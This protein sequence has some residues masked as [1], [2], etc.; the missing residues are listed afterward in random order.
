MTDHDPAS[1]IERLNALITPDLHEHVDGTNRAAVLGWGTTF[2]VL[3]LVKGVRLL[4]EAD[5]CYVAMPLM[6]SML[7][8]AMG[9]IWIAD[10]QEDAVEVLNRRLLGQHN[11]LLKDLGGVDLE[12]LVGAETVAAF[13]RT[14]AEK[15]DP[16]PDERLI[17]FANLLREYNL[18]GLVPIYDVLSG[19]AHLSTQAAGAFF[20]TTDEAA[21]L[22]LEPRFGEVVACEELCL[23]VL[24]DTMKAYNALL[25]GRPWSD[26]LAAIAADYADLTTELPKRRKPSG[27]S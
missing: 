18:D 10:A 3:H 24:F 9:T 14:R 27:G 21:R 1:G 13:M 26:A 15:L 5:S 12:A 23:L 20:Q 25:A 17:G 19:Q 11:K 7:E 4:H 2:N 16:H 6:R 22:W 8:F